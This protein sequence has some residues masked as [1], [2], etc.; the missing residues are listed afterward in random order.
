MMEKILYEKDGKI[1][2]NQYLEIHVPLNYFDDKFAVDRGSLVETIGLLFVTPYIDG[3]SQ[4]KKLLN[5]PTAIEIMLYDSINEEI[6]VHG[7]PVKVM[8]L[9]YMKDSYVLHQTVQKGREVAG[10]FL[11]LMLMGKLPD[12][13]NYPKVLD[14]WWRNLEISGVSYK[15]PSKI[16][17]LII[18]NIYRNPNNTKERFGELYGKQSPPDGF[19]YET[20]NVR[21]VVEGLSTF[22]GMIFED[23]NRMIT[24]G[25]NNS[26]DG[27]E[28]PVSPLEK[29]IY[30]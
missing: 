8:T 1:Y 23:I 13:L 3:K 24:S 14:I 6:Q 18:A 29:I 26:L 17:E 19:N 10:A 7:K 25:I 22:S 4:G 28:E 9:K 12:V 21:D 27:I 5:I 2:T 16:Y 20:G 11:N 15:V 30:Y